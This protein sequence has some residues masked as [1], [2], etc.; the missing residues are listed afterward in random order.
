MRINAKVLVGAVCALAVVAGG[1]SVIAQSAQEKA[2]QDKA[3]VEKVIVQTVAG[4][5]EGQVRVTA[6]PGADNF[7]F[8]STEMSLT[9]KLVKGAPYSADAV[10]EMTQVLGDGN[11]IVNR[12]TASVKS[13][14]TT[15]LP[16]RLFTS[17]LSKCITGFSVKCPWP[18]KIAPVS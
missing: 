15:S 9:E 18:T 17:S 14:S 5:Q 8:V 2:A 6:G 11:R 1:S 13:S 4:G 7:V 10:T 12:N 3:A 16:E